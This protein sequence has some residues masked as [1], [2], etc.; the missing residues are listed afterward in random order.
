MAR[1][2]NVKGLSSR[3][4]GRF[5][6]VPRWAQET[7][8]NFGRNLPKPSFRPFRS[9]LVVLAHRL[10]FPYPG[11]G[12]VEIGRKPLRRCVRCFDVFTGLSGRLVD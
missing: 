4:P 6:A 3:Q 9:L 12:G 1:A 11:L 7:L 10:K 2:S 8:L 5:G